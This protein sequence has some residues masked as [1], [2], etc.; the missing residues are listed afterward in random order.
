MYQEDPSF[1]LYRPFAVAEPVRGEP[2]SAGWGCR[3]CGRISPHRTLYCPA[4]K[5]ATCTET[6]CEGCGSARAEGAAFECLEDLVAFALKTEAEEESAAATIDAY[7]AEAELQWPTRRNVYGDELDNPDERAVEA[8]E[9]FAPL[10]QT[11]RLS[12]YDQ[13]PNG[14]LDEMVEATANPMQQYLDLLEP[15][16]PPQAVVPAV[17]RAGR[18]RRLLVQTLKSA[19]A[20]LEEP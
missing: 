19:I 9:V 11:R 10:A 7:C 14:D 18:W 4:C 15:A 17:A 5:S 20:I 6:T 13:I 3:A 16:P 2:G 8:A 12:G 1:S